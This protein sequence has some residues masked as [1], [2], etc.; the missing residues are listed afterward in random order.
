MS[1]CELNI[2]RIF[3]NIF[4]R[5][6]L[7]SGWPQPGPFLMTPKRVFIIHGYKSRPNDCWFP[8]LK[9]ELTRKGFRVNALKMPSPDRPAMREWVS[10]LKKAVGRPD[11]HVYLVGH[12]L[13]GTAI[14][15]YLET[16]RAGQ[17]IGGAVL[18]AGRILRMPRSKRAA[19]FFRKP[20]NWE[21]IRRGGRKFI[22]IY[23]ADDHVVPLQ[24][25]LFLKKKLGAK[26]IIEKNK[27]HFCFLAKKK[28]SRGR[29]LLRLPSA[30]AA[31]MSISK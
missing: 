2:G 12:S 11:E 23:S 31:V 13:G 14:L 20:F 9:K 17:K 1:L 6:E 27:K 16:L 29:K 30:L 24:N 10:V 21:K 7:C 19:G 18:V 8:W 15:R 26:L 4:H 22:G 28:T 3:I 5:A 25:G